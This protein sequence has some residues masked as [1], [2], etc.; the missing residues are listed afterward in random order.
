MFLRST[1]SHS[2]V[3]HTHSIKMRLTTGWG[4]D[5]LGIRHVFQR[6]RLE[7]P[8]VLVLEDLDSLINDA[9]RSFFLNEVDGLE[10][11]DGLL[12]V[13][14][15]ISPTGTMADHRSAP[16]TTLTVWTRHCPVV[17]RDSTGNSKPH[18]LS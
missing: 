4:G 5:E 3:R 16:L 15:C 9:N 13:R 17:P 1:S 14:H 11:N 8:C 6:A 10:D 2:T 7:A 18:R 12:M